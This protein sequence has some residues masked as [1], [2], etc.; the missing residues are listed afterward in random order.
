LNILDA[1]RQASDT[2]PRLLA[3]Q[4]PST[5]VATAGRVRFEYWPRPTAARSYPVI[6]TKQATA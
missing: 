3:I 4:S 1:T 2:G 6:Y 5:V